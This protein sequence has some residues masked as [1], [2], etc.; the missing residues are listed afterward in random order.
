MKFRLLAFFIAVF[1]FQLNSIAQKKDSPIAIAIHGGAGTILKENMS[2]ELEK[3]YHDKLSEALDSGYQV[4]KNGGASVEA[5]IAAIKILEDSPLFNAGKGAVL[6]NEGNAELDAA[7]MDGKTL[8][9]G[10][11][12][13]LTTI[14]NPILGAKVV[15]DKSPH[16]MMIGKGAE[17]FVISQNVE[18]VHPDYF[19]TEQRKEQLQKILDAEEGKGD[20]KNQHDY[21][22]G[23]V[24]AVALDKD[25]NLAAGTSTGGMVNKKFGRVG[26]SPIIGSG[27]YADNESC[28]V[29]C[30]GHGEYFI[31]YVVAHDISSLM[32]YKKYSVK[33]AGDELIYQKLLKAGG[34]GGAI[35]LDK[36]GNIYMPFNTSGMYRGMIDTKG[37][38]ITKIYE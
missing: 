35:I 15:M 21:K 12:A 8:K 25:G 22:F 13:G 3:E 1:S 38:K 37:N 5:V 31:R 14:K 9:A 32:K 20:L 4:L 2:F 7:I 19:K 11:V 33:K 26:D 16:V 36:K 29:S 30:T 28:A 10:A 18:T 34:R 24:G 17:Q 6:N 23:T 27:T